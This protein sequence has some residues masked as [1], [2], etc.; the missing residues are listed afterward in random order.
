MLKGIAKITVVVLEDAEVELLKIDIVEGESSNVS[1]G[2]RINIDVNTSSV[3]GHKVVAIRVRRPI[4]S[5]GAAN[6]S[7]CI[8]KA[9]RAKIIAVE[10][11]RLRRRIIRGKS[12]VEL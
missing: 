9:N 5:R 3:E 8:E 4:D 11:E 7:P 2:V 12:R 6:G 10:M 1:T